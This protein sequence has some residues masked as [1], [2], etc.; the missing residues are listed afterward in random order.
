MYIIFRCPNAARHF[1]VY[2]GYNAVCLYFT[3]GMPCVPITRSATTTTLP[4]PTPP[5]PHGY[6]Q[7]ARRPLLTCGPESVH[8]CSCLRVPAYNLCSLPWLK[9]VCLPPAVSC[10]SPAMQ[11]EDLINFSEHGAEGLDKEIRKE[12]VVTPKEDDTSPEQYERLDR[13][14]QLEQKVER[15]KMVLELLLRDKGGEKDVR[16]PVR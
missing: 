1:D 11:M 6:S 16:R 2:R 10:C 4:Q 15:M 3:P 5:I 8:H 12:E 9:T 14:I 13:M 7:H